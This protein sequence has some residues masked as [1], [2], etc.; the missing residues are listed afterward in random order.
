M[1]PSVIVALA[2]TVGSAIS[3]KRPA[4]EVARPTDRDAAA[5]ELAAFERAWLEPAKI[6]APVV[7]FEA[8]TATEGSVTVTAS[9]LRPEDAAWNTWPGPT[10]RLFNNRAALLFE[11]AI[12]ADGPVAW[13]PE[14][15]G[16]EIN[17]VGDALPPA[18]SAE[19]L[20]VPLLTAALQQERH[21]LPGDHVERTRSAG[22][23]RSA[24]L[25]LGAHGAPLTGLI[26]FPLADPERHVVA[27]RL[28]LGVSG[29]DGPH[30]IALLFE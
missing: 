21:G 5:E 1:R 22:A 2:C 29:P 25:P 26:A 16:L 18:E 9:P 28:T 23:F 13:I 11:V 27:F 30:A 8:H 10:V 19:E 3:C 12:D 7:A 14:R 24:Y 4:W 6:P 15:T 17:E 20:L